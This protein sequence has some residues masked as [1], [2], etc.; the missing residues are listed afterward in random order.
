[1]GGLGAYAITDLDVAS[2]QW[3]G[4]VVAHDGEGRGPFSVEAQSSLTAVRAQLR[5]RL[6]LG[7]VRGPRLAGP[8]VAYYGSPGTLFS[9]PLRA[10]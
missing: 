3:T 10:Q 2:L 4:L 7:P 8:L 6:G 9:R 5:V 1:M